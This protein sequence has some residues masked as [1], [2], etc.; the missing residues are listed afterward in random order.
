MLGGLTA[1][2]QTLL[3]SVC[4]KYWMFQ[5]ESS[6]SDDEYA[7]SVSTTPPKPVLFAHT[8]S[9]L[10]L[11]WW[12]DWLWVGN[13]I[14]DV[15]CLHLCP[16]NSRVVSC[17]WFVFLYFL[18]WHN[19]LSSL[20]EMS[21]RYKTELRSNRLDNSPKNWLYFRVWSQWDQSFHLFSPV[22]CLCISCKFSSSCH[23]L[24]QMCIYI[25]LDTVLAT[26]VNK[27]SL[28]SARCQ[29][30]WR[31]KFGE[32]DLFLAVAKDCGMFSSLNQSQQSTSLCFG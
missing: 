22:N 18:T 16:L 24:P 7:F 6:W 14:V 2:S 31:T 29:P 17:L 26:D 25:L 1:M 20:I 13:V 15:P 27:Y 11:I 9:M 4:L 32:P 5:D 19:F 8:I 3:C 30:I 12:A 28:A 21:C 10:Q 23:S